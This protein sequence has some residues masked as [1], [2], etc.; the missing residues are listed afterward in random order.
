[1]FDAVADKIASGPWNS[2]FPKIL[3]EPVKNTEPVISLREPV[4]FPKKKLCDTKSEPETMA[5]LPI[6]TF[7]CMVR[8]PEIFCCSSICLRGISLAIIL[9]LL[10]SL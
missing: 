2:N 1:V 9:F 5:S 8:E 6:S 3:K 4:L 10:F 7:C